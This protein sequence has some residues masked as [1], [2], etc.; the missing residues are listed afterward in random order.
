MSGYTV[1]ELLATIDNGSRPSFFELEII[2]R[3][4]S[5]FQPT[6][7]HFLEAI[8]EQRQ[9]PLLLRLSRIFS[10]IPWILLQRA[11]LFRDNCTLAER[12]YSIERC[13]INPIEGRIN[14]NK[15]GLSRYQ[16]NMSFFFIAIMPHVMQYWR[17]YSKNRLA[18]IEG[19]QQEEGNQNDEDGINEEI[20][21]TSS[22]SPSSSSSSRWSAL[23]LLPWSW[24]WFSPVQRFSLDMAAKVLPFV[25]FSYG[26]ACTWQKFAYMFKINEYFSPELALIGVT[27]RRRKEDAVG[28]ASTT[29]GNP[30]I[31][32]TTLN[33]NHLMIA[34][35]IALKAMEWMSQENTRTDTVTPTAHVPPP[36]TTTSNPRGCIK[37]SSIKDSKCPLCKEPQRNPCASTGGYVFCHSCIIDALQISPKCPVTG[38]PCT[39]QDL[40][41]LYQTE[42]AT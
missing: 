33:L 39:P 18:E 19:R 10:V 21:G 40:I 31:L 4:E 6:M 28:E 9:S 2:E 26:I 36:P 38:F 32:P 7:Q 13:S 29:R 27:F 20:D 12:V 15:N 5:M 42:D 3:I 37:V 16:K 24:S 41:R 14:R 35:L 1:N 30:S 8:G 25:E 11:I 17:D 22:L 34:V 23:H